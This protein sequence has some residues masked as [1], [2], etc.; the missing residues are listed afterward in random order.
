MKKKYMILGCIA[1][2]AIA[3]TSIGGAWSYFTTYTEAQGTRTITLGDWTNINERYE[4]GVKYVSIESREDSQPV[5][6]RVQGFAGSESGDLTYTPQVDGDWTSGGDGYWYYTKA[7]NGGET[8]SEI[9]VSIPQQLVNGEKDF[10]VVVVYESA[11]VLNDENGDPLA[12]NSETV[13]T[14]QVNT[15]A[16]GE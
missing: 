3:S 15:E 11:P 13:W 5:Y 16:G 8:T 10:N 6:V 1:A 12:Y 14:H 2:V 9:A 4:S 7:L